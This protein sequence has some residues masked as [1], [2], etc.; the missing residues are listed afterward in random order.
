MKGDLLKQLKSGACDLFVSR[1]CL[2]MAS[3]FVGFLIVVLKGFF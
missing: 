2:K 3:G 1:W